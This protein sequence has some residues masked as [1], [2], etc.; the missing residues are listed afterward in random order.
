MRV[1]LEMSYQ[2]NGQNT[3]TLKPH[4]NH[5]DSGIC[6]IT[7]PTASFLSWIPLRVF[8]ISCCT[9]TGFKPWWDISLRDGGEIF[10]CVVAYI[11]AIWKSSRA[12]DP[13]KTEDKMRIFKPVVL[14]FTSASAFFVVLL[15]ASALTDEFDWDSYQQK[16]NSLQRLLMLL[17]KPVS[18]IGF[19]QISHV[20]AVL[21]VNA[22]VRHLWLTVFSC[23]TVTASFWLT[24]GVA[25]GGGWK[26]K[27]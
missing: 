23:F 3:A 14:G 22:L 13:W 21:Q 15:V 9:M 24:A 6:N 18:H 8:F 17:H 20:T 26:Q 16:N 19:A 2:I 7:I 11:T 27:S 10:V 25:A 1:A 5:A 4:R 12:S